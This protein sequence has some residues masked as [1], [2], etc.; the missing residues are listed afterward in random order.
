MKDR[1]QVVTTTHRMPWGPHSEIVQEWIDQPPTHPMNPR[2][3]ASRVEVEGRYS[4]FE[5]A[6]NIFRDRGW[7]DPPP[8]EYKWADVTIY[9]EAPAEAMDHFGQLDTDGRRTDEMP[10]FGI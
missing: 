1:S 9:Y 2:Y 5:R 7:L 10:A 3:R 6:V 4:L 8:P